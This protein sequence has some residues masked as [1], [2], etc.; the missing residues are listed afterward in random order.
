MGTLFLWFGYYGFNCGSTL[1]TNGDQSLKI[2]I[3]AINTT[4][5]SVGGALCTYL[6]AHFRGDSVRN[7][8]IDTCKGVLAGLI[9]ITGCCDIIE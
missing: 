5:G 8:L 7:Q 2:G 4:L 6:L 9:A 3:I 1:R